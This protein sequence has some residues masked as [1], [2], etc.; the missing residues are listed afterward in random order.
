MRPSKNIIV[1]L[2]AMLLLSALSLYA[3][4]S[5]PA[6]AGSITY[7]PGNGPGGGKHIV[8]VTGDE[9]DR[10]TTIWASA[11]LGV[12]VAAATS[13]FFEVFG[14]NRE[15]NRGPNTATF[16]AGVVYLFNPDVQIDVRAARRLT[17]SGLDLL[18]GAGLSWRFG[19]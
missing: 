1:K 6:Q 16:Q 4:D 10:Y 19:G 12:E 8:F 15:E 18:I 5:A 17:S 9:E 14:F 3:A 13:V 11:A 2:A 7:E